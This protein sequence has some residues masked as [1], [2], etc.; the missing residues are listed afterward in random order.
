[1]KKLN[2]KLSFIIP[3]KDESKSIDILYS[4]ILR[5]MQKLNLPYEIIFIDD[6]SIDNTFTKMSNLRKKD[7]NVKII[8]FRGNF[9]KSAALDAG[10]EMAKGGTIFTLDAD[11]QDDPK[12]IHK[13]LKKLEQG[14]DLVVGWKKKRNDPVGKVLPSRVLN[15][16]AG[17]LTKTNLH[18][19]NCGFKAYKSEVAKNLNLYGEL[20]RFIPIIVAKKNY[21]VD[22]VAIKHRVRKFGKSKYG[23]SRIPRGFLDLLTVVFITG[24]QGRPGH[25]FGSLGLISFSFGFAIGSYIAYLRFSTGS[26]QNRHPLLFLGMLLMIIGVQLVTTGL[27]A[28]LTVNFNRNSKATNNIRE[29]HK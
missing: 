13:F 8:R 3:A 2:S 23:I 11:L 20:Y 1:M 6:G 28:E 19:I 18:D 27:I 14:A 5:E 12:E 22:E 17:K 25:F 21:K 24:Y 7:K 15:W 9:G 26:I 29:L 16:I 4:E 10:F